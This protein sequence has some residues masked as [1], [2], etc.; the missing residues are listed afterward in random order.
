M[1]RLIETEA[2]VAFHHLEP[3]YPFHVLLVP[4]QAIQSLAEL[5]EKDGRL[6]A[7]SFQVVQQLVARFDLERRGY[8]LIVNGGKFQDVP[9]L[10]FHLISDDP[11]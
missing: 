9:I 5:G 1:K 3:G 7:E 6:L 4:K 8:R 10:H 11:N 2:W